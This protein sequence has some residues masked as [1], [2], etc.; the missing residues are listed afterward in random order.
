MF[1]KKKDSI[2]IRKSD[3]NVKELS[4]N[5]EIIIQI[6]RVISCIEFDLKFKKW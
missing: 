4:K 5:K 2:K 1:T 3:K 6:D